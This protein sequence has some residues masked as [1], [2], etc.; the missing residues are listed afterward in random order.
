MEEAESGA[1]DVFPA[2]VKLNIGGRKFQTSVATL[3]A[4]TGMLD[5]M[6]SGKIGV[7]KDD[8]GKGV[9]TCEMSGLDGLRCD[10]FHL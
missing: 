4:E 7:A 3:R 6:F 2:V 9:Q 1:E 8:Q 10:R 5:A